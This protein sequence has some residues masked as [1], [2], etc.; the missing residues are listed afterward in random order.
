MAV[1]IPINQNGAEIG[2]VQITIL[3]KKLK[4]WADGGRREKGLAPSA[5][6]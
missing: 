2:A 3:K 1:P 5:I 4:I 6:R